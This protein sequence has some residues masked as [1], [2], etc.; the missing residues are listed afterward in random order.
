VI[1]FLGLTATDCYVIIRRVFSF[2]ISAVPTRSCLVLFRTA[3]L[4]SNCRFTDQDLVQPHAPVDDDGLAKFEVTT[5]AL[6]WVQ[7]Y[8][9]VTLCRWVKS[10]VVSEDLNAFF[11]RAKQPIVG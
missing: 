3:I 1:E 2:Q 10:G 8:L 6:V 4:L 5:A 9:V 7:V 11:V